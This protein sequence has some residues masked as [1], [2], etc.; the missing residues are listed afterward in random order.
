MPSS[1]SRKY[2]NLIPEIFSVDMFLAFN[3]FLFSLLFDTFIFS[4]VPFIKGRLCV[5]VSVP[6]NYRNYNFMTVDEIPSIHE[7][8]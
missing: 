8:Q 5:Y 2:T 7:W 6:F 1:I 4:I 3:T